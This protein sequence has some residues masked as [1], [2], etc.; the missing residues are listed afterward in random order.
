MRAV[1]H[2]GK[3]RVAAVGLGWVA[4]HRHLPAMQR[5]GEFEVLGVIDR[6]PGRARTVMSN[7]GYRCSAEAADLTKIEWLSDIDAITVATAPMSHYSIIRQA[8]ELGK[9]VLTE[10]PFA[11][12][13]REGEEL[14][15]LSRAQ[16]L[17]LAIMHNFQFARSTAKLLA[18]ISSGRLGAIRG[19]NAV[20]L[21]N[22]RRRLPQWF[23]RLPLGLFYDES[24]H[25]LYLIRRVAGDLRLGD[26][27]VHRS[28]TGLNTPAH[29]DAYFESSTVPGPVTLS[30]NFESPV[31]EWYLMVFGHDRL[32]IVDVFRDIYLSLPNDGAHD[33]ARVFRTSLYATGQ[34]LWQHITSGIPHLTGKLLYGNDEVFARFARAIRNPSEELHFIGAEDALAVLKLQHEIINK[35]QDLGGTIPVKSQ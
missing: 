8:L 12:T 34:H 10:K 28:T 23:E 24:P 16:G 14:A 19:I 33:T 29:I 22:P 7:R 4:T 11:M 32:G 18:E 5:S 20:Q 35:H 30:C 27:L 13:V 3:L 17:R 9:H 1:S 31:S 2:T 15:A 6:S 21:G 26:C 25:L